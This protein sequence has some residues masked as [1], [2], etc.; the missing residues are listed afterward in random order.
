MIGAAAIHDALLSTWLS[1]ANAPAFGWLLATGGGPGSAPDAAHGG[2]GTGAAAHPGD[3]DSPTS[4]A[5]ANWAESALF[6]LVDVG[7]VTLT[8]GMV[9]MLFRILRGPQL[10]D[11]VLAGDALSLHVVGLVILLAIRLR[12]EVFFDAAIIVAIIGFASTL[13][14]AQ[15]IGNRRRPR[16]Q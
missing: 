8:L 4:L 9:L 6:L 2:G 5:G 15:Y 7:M 12:T 10:A 3:F 14:F 1:A 13:A 16:T 11:R